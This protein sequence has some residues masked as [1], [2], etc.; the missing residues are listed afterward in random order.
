M[1]FEYVLKKD[2]KEIA[3]KKGNKDLEKVLKEIDSIVVGLKE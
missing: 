3:G 2:G 1:E